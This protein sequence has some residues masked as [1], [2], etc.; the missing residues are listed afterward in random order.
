MIATRSAS[1]MTTDVA[2]L[3]EVVFAEEG[4][5][6]EQWN[7]IVPVRTRWEVLTSL[8]TDRDGNGSP[9][10]D[11]RVVEAAIRSLAAVAELGPG[12]LPQP[13]VVPLSGG[14]VHFE[15]V[16]G[17]RQLQVAIFPD[18]PADFLRVEG[19]AVVD[20]GALRLTAWEHIRALFAWLTPATT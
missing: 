15:W 1:A 14:G 10:P 18:A 3:H 20:Q 13:H 9:P 12:L 8:P 2:A 16:V 5:Q 6:R 19:R 11:P 7:A 17:A 4:A